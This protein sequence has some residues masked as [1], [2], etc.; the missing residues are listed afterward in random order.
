MIKPS[1]EALE[2]LGRECVEFEEQFDAKM[3]AALEFESRHASL[4]GAQPRFRLVPTAIGVWGVERLDG[5][6]PGLP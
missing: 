3:E 2:R 6:P 5:G 4:G 1:P